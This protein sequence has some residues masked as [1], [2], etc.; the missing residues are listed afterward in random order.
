MTLA[1]GLR[2]ALHQVRRSPAF[3]AVATLSLALGIGA[4]ILAATRLMT[5]M[6]FGVR[7]ADPTTI[8]G[9][10]LLMAVVAALA[11]FLPA[12]KAARVDPMTALRYE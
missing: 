10:A 6:L 5:A 3:T 7:P 12:R 4:T 8:A 9:A 2:Y 1:Q 11:S